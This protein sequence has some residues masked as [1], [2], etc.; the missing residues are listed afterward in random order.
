MAD[1]SLPELSHMLYYEMARR[2]SRDPA[3]RVALFEGTEPALT[4]YFGRPI[5]LAGL[6]PE[7]RAKW[8]QA[9]SQAQARY[10]HK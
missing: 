7:D 10:S 1:E 4:A 9:V 8:E 2:A 3:F 6:P 5:S